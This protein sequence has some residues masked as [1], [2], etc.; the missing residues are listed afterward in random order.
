MIFRATIL[1]SFHV[2]FFTSPVE[3]LASTYCML[4]MSYLTT[5]LYFFIGG[6]RELGDVSHVPSPD[7]ESA[8]IRR[9]RFSD[10]VQPLDRTVRTVHTVR[11]AASK[12]KVHRRSIQSS[13]DS[14][15]QRT[16]Y[17]DDLT[18]RMFCN[19]K[20]QSTR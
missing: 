3:H 5:I 1:Y 10:Q 13:L 12:C 6:V 18:S 9:P 7:D 8:I 16:T 14:E 11:E 15:V 17:K 20:S 4:Q 2:I 19:R